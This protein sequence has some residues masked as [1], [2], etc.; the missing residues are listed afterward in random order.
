[1]LKRIRNS[2][3]TKVLA[4]YVALLMLTDLFN[5]KQTFAL[6]SG[7]SQPE[8]QSFEPIG[9][10]DMVDLFSGDFI[11]NIPLVDV[12]GYPVNLSYHS[13]IGMDQEASWVGLGW[14]INPG[15]IN[16]NMRSIPDDFNGNDDK[17]LKEFNMKD[18]NT[19]GLTP[20]IDIAGEFFGVSFLHLGLG[21]GVS[22]NNYK[23]IG[24]K[25]IVEPSISCGDNTKGSMTAGLGLTASSD[26]DFGLDPSLSFKCEADKSKKN[27]TSLSAS[28]GVPYNTSTGLQSM[29]LGFNLRQQE[30]SSQSSRSTYTLGSISSGSA[31]SF[32]SPSYT[33]SYDMPMMNSSLSFNVTL[34]GEIF[35]AHANLR[36]TGFYNGQFLQSRHEDLPAY[37][38]MYVHNGT[39]NKK[40]LKTKVMLDFNREKDGNFTKNTPALPLT[41]FNYDIYSVSGQGIGGMYRPFRG[42]VGILYD[43]NHKNEGTNINFPGIETGFGNGTHIGVNLTGGHTTSKSGK[44]ADGNMLGAFLNFKGK[45]DDDKAYE[46]YYFKQAGEKTVEN[47]EAFFNSVGRFDPIRVSLNQV[48]E[49]TY[50]NAYY[51]HSIDENEDNRVNITSNTRKERD[52]R[53]QNIS[54]LTASDAS[55][56]GVNKSIPS[57]GYN[58]F[59]IVTAMGSTS[60]GSY[61]HEYVMS[62]VDNSNANPK[63]RSAHHISEITAVRSD[64]ARYIYGI[65]AYN[66]YQEE[67]AFAT[68]GN[69]DAKGL[70]TYDDQSDNSLYNNKG[71]DNFYEKTVMP[72]YAHSYLL[73]DILSVDYVDNDDIIGPSDGDY[74]TYTKINYHKED[75]QYN[76]RTP[77]ENANFSEGFKSD[78]DDNKANYVYGR[79]EVWY[80]HSIETKTHVA[81]FYLSERKD[82]F[83]AAGSTGGKGT[84]PMKKLDK[85]VLYSKQDKIKNQDNAIPIKTVHFTYDYSLCPNVLNN[86]DGVL[87]ENEEANQGGKLT[88]K[89]VYFTYGKSEKGM[90]DPY[91]FDYA[92]VKVK[93]P[94]GSIETE[95]Q[96]NPDYNLKGYD[97]WGNFSPNPTSVGYNWDDERTNAEAPYVNQKKIGELDQTDLSTFT[98]TGTQVY[99]ESNPE[100]SWTDLYSYAWTLTGITTPSGSEINMNYESDDYAFVQNKKAMNM[101]KVVDCMSSPSSTP[102]SASDL[103]NLYYT[104]TDNNINN[105]RYLYFE[106]NDPILASDE[107]A[108]AKL[109][110]YFLD[111]NGNKIKYLFFKFLVNLGEPSSEKFE[112]VPG[113]VNIQ[114]IAGNVEKG[115]AAQESGLYNHAWVLIPEIFCDKE[116]D[117]DLCNPIS[118]AAWHFARLHL[119]PVAYG[120][121]DVNATGIKQIMNALAGMLSSIKS[122]YQGF[123]KRMQNSNQGK[124][125]VVGK[126]WIRLY[127]SDGEKHGGGSRVKRLTIADNWAKM[128][129]GDSDPDK[130]VV[131]GQEYDYTTKNKNGEIISSGVAA[132]EPIIGGE[133]NPWR[134]PVFYSEEKLLAP[135]EEFY[136]EEPFGESFFPGA[137]VGYSKVTVKNLQWKNFGTDNLK[138]V[139]T[140][141][142]GKVVNEFYTS[143]D[144]PTYP[145]M[146]PLVKAPY[147]S[148]PAF[149]LLKIENT[150]YMTASQGYSIEL[151]DMHG[152]E[153]AK[154]VYAENKEEPIS[155]VQYF[156]KTQGGIYIENKANYLDNKV[157]AIYKNSQI[158]NDAIMGVDYDF[159]VDMRNSENKSASGGATGNLDAFLAGII[160]CV[161]PAIFPSF[162][163]EKV[164]F[165]SAVTTKVINRY[166][167]LERVVAYDLGSTVSTENKLF[168]ALTGEVL[169]TKTANQFNDPI[170]SFTYPAYWTYDR[171]GPAYKNVGIEFKN[172]TFNISNASQY[173]VKWDELG[174]EYS[175]NGT[176]RY[177]WV[178]EVS[179]SGIEV[180]DRN[181]ATIPN[182]TYNV[183]KILRS[184]RRNQSSLPVGTITSLENPISG[185][186]IVFNQ[187]TKIINATSSEYSD[188]WKLFCEC[189]YIPDETIINE[190]IEGIRGNWRPCKSNVYITDR[191]QTLEDKNVNIRRDGYYK[192]F[193]PFWTP[194]TG[195]ATDWIKDITNWTWT[196][197][198]TEYSPQGFELENRDALK[199]Y[200][201]AVYGYNYS[202]PISVSSNA[203]YREIANDNFEDYDFSSC[204]KDHFSYR[205]YYF[206][207]SNQEA[208]SGRRSI[209]VSP[210]SSINC[211]R[212]LLECVQDNSDL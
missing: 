62:R 159:A 113:Y 176:T 6:T 81:E 16:R 150:E 155:G 210:N 177:G 133:E 205:L 197:E 154:W 102:S 48:G 12:G 46:P 194:P 13:G 39:S 111:E 135:S 122:F 104:D 65:P 137:S 53:T 141:A 146:T 20:V 190:C 28:I 149:K 186:T 29:S 132:Y 11:Y 75:A 136:K 115:F 38:Y 1:M 96:I 5:V 195:S 121:Q 134:F 119:P 128:A 108:N 175:S 129:Y 19:Y 57:Y 151:N 109:N 79:K 32:A 50:A 97:R 156:Y 183:I 203:M 4:V 193:S 89:S 67:L 37:G 100:R 23:G 36:A 88:L 21:L 170:Y 112:Y 188:E 66:T 72:P 182:I 77:Y 140:N 31:I 7:P 101:M 208:H 91:V 87:D 126:S 99:D 68:E 201:S 84:M 157:S 139:T 114:D 118:K 105:N 63:I 70:V 47:D 123:N 35:G 169:L 212:T 189:G 55:K 24:M 64:G 86:T 71:R 14:N 83:D 44:W 165:R 42:D 15:V 166:G 173:F 103:N 93:N 30:S 94:G 124:E 9:T 130:V 163:Q 98:G 144:Y 59:T 51:V 200:S 22:Y 167:I 106:L 174:L 61:L 198:V 209:S 184:G 74:G 80:V 90:L 3:I 172:S 60:S 160:P 34:G 161:I 196:S 110:K 69:C 131:Y 192:D 185:N 117:S 125:F 17:V 179:S 145:K 26:G 116:N 158:N 27:T 211:G 191:I 10:S 204:G 142:T 171:M 54:V 187:N 107:N 8:V 56:Y 18:N 58:D 181:G 138:N 45:V 82:G 85:I 202:L 152:K 33:P 92:K 78:A 153:K 207:I 164:R 206:K 168:D 127:N 40:N 41:S 143:K 2:K 199:R 76:W 43:S 178:K 162:S 73:T 148:S 95:L 120:D 180:I 25:M 147:K 52:K 49:E